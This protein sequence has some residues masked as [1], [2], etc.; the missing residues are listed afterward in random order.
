MRKKEHKLP[1]N[2]R[3]SAKS[4]VVPV[5][6]QKSHEY[7]AT[8]AAVFGNIGTLIA[9]QV[10]A[11]DAEK[12]SEQLGGGLMPQDLMTLPRYAAYARLLIEGM[13]SRPFSMQT[14][15]P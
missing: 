9:F 3:N 7:T 10:G 8:L 15:P 5:D 6:R 14:L 4:P 12:V 1:F 2:T 11:E 13:P